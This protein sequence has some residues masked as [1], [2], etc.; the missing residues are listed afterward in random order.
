MNSP[1]VPVM[2]NE[3][4]ELIQPKE[5]G[6]YLDCTFGAGGYTRGILES[7]NCKVYAID[8]DAQVVPFAED[9]K[10][11]FGVDR[12][13]FMLGKFSCLEDLLFNEGVLSG[14]DGIVFDLGMSSMQIDSEERGFSFM[15]E[16]SP[17]DM[18]MGFS[19]FKAY[20][21]VN[22][23]TESYIAKILYENSG[24]RYSKKIAK[25]IVRARRDKVIV[26]TGDL[27]KI[28]N[29]VVPRSEKI[30]P[31]TRTFQAIRIF[32]NNE[33]EE[34]KMALDS[35]LKIL[36]VKG[37]ILAV[38]FHS[39]EDSIVKEK[40]NK[41]CGKSFGCNRNSPEAL[42]QSRSVFKFVSLTKNALRATA[43]E[44]ESNARCRSARLRCVE[45][46]C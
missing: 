15:K 7:S 42:R 38:S 28:V 34:L 9:M 31:C 14:I 19:E 16:S 30:D 13:C 22:K 8:R 46:S 33:L 41:I 2:L 6:V 29:S 24:E 21:F 17:L 44:I 27:S 36:S 39:L 23:S 10:K 40:F 35:A 43:E 25:A 32:I 26:T 11:V 5:G 45:K 12:F 20:D 4:L 3:V 1:H 37:R 18:R